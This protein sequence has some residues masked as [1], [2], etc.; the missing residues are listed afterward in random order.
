MIL[1]HPC[2]SAGYLKA[3]TLIELLVV[4][5]IIAVLA[6]LTTSLA[7][8]ATSAGRLA[9]TRGEMHQIQTA[10]DSYQSQLNFFPPDNRLNPAVNPL[11]YELSGVTTSDGLMF[12]TKNRGENISSAAL[13]NFFGVEGILNQAKEARNARSYANF[14]ASQY[15]EISSNPDVEVL[16]AP[17]KMPLSVKGLAIPQPIPGK[18][19]LNPWRYVSTGPTNNPS[20]YDLWVDLVISGKTNRISNW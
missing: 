7:G 12:Q 16:V 20:R 19:G 15:A 4:I 13:K 2:G 14:K 18:P 6:G 5:S 1:R 3:F 11:F 17:V 10:I 9:R 8:R